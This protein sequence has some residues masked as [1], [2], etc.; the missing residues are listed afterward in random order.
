MEDCQQDRWTL[1]QPAAQARLPV[2]RHL[3][4]SAKEMKTAIA[5]LVAPGV[6][7]AVFLPL[8]ALHVAIFGT[9]GMPEAHNLAS[10]GL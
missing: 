6:V 5:F 7:P 1:A 8:Y 10:I 2:Q 3:R 4:R 9:I